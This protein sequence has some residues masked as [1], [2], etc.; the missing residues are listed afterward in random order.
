MERGGALCL[1]PDCPVYSLRNIS[2]CDRLSLP[3]EN[4]APHFA[5]LDHPAL[6]LVNL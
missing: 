6:M 3:T 4:L 2:L 1:R 5:L